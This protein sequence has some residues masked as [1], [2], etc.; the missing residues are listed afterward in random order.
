MQKSGKELKRAETNHEGQVDDLGESE[1]KA[2]SL[3]N[4]AMMK[5]SH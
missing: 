1:W 2:L 4:M 3:E 5:V